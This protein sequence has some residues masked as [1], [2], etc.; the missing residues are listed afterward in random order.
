MYK[1]GKVNRWD[2]EKGSYRFPCLTTE[3]TY[4]RQ[5]QDGGRQS[6]DTKY[7]QLYVLLNIC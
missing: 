7:A 5:I 4:H 2:A 1:T 3:W 6:P